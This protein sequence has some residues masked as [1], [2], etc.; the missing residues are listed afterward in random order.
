MPLKPAK[1]LV[2]SSLREDVVAAMRTAESTERGSR[3]A[4]KRRCTSLHC[5]TNFASS[6]SRA[7][8]PCFPQ[9]PHWEVLAVVVVVVGGGGGSGGGG[10]GGRVGRVSMPPAK[11]RT[12]KRQTKRFVVTTAFVTNSLKTTGDL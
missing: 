8:G 10:G 3:P 1:M 12:A 2:Q 6:W 11:Y 5:L 4:T 9:I 7:N